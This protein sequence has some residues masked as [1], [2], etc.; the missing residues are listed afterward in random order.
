MRKLKHKD[1][2]PLCPKHLKQLRNGLN[3][4]LSAYTM[5][6]PYCKMYTNIDRKFVFSNDPLAISYIEIFEWP[7]KNHYIL[8]GQEKKIGEQC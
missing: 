5:P 3:S 8:S 2:K 1:A 4:S 7:S 6:P